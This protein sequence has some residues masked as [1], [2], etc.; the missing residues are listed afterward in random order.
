M[1]TVMMIVFEDKVIGDAPGS[2]D[3]KV[4]FTFL[5][6]VEAFSLSDPEAG[7]ECRS[8][9]RQGRIPQGS[10]YQFEGAGKLF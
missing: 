5:Q 1:L 9:L 6:F 7:E 2:L 10:P 8:I 4:R 3:L